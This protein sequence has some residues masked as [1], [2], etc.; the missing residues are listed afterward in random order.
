MTYTREQIQAMEAGRGLDRLVGEH[1]MQFTI[2]HYDKDIEENCYC[3][4]MDNEGYSVELFGGERETED[5]AWLDSPHYSTDIA[6]AWEAEG[7][8][9][10][11][12]GVTYVYR[13][14]EVISLTSIVDSEGLDDFITTCSGN[15]LGL[16]HATPAQRCKAALLAV[17]G[18]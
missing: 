7:V 9:M 11:E 4:L 10:W 17:L 6:A 1:V 12:L 18:L 8:V 15:L 5:E 14:A 16:I 3:M 13:L 2:Y